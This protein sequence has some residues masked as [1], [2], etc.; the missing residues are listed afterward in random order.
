[1]Q[2]LDRTPIVAALVIAS[3]ASVPARAMPAS[4]GTDACLAGHSRATSFDRIAIPDDQPQGVTLGP[5][6]IADSGRIE[7]IVLAVSLTHPNAADVT[8][9]LGYDADRD[10]RPDVSSPVAIYLARRD[11]CRGTEA[12]ACPLELTGT[13][14]FKDDGWQEVGESVSFEVFAGLEA[15]GDWYLTIVDSGPHHVGTVSGWEIAARTLR[16]GDEPV[17]A[18]IASCE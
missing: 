16:D 3:L 11:L 18:R 17:D 13:Y 14:F 12:W 8:M 9:T 1:M 6:H 10:G 4:A 2:Q 5:L 7:E 15:C